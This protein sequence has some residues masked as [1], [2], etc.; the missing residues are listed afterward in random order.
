MKRNWDVIRKILLKIEDLPP[1][2]SIHSSHLVTDEIDEWNVAHQMFILKQGG[3]IEGNC[4]DTGRGHTCIARTLTWE[5]QELLDK[6]RS[7]SIW[8][9]IKETAREK[10]VDLTIDVVKGIAS[11]VLAQI[12]RGGN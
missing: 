9:K 3:F 5:G 11:M 6:I 12:V 2:G 7:E 4:L 1:G 8:Q 10:R